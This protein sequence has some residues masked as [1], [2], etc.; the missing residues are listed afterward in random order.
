[1]SQ[2]SA[3]DFDC[4]NSEDEPIITTWRSFDLQAVAW[5]QAVKNQNNEIISQRATE[6]LHISN[7]SW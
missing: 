2:W 1:M 6:K 4:F 5:V 7:V 3:S